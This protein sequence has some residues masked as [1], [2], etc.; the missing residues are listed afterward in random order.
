TESTLQVANTP[1]QKVKPG[2][3]GRPLPGMDVV[4]ID[5]VTNE[6]GDSGEICL[7]IDPRPVGLTPGYYGDPD[8]NANVFRDGF[9]HT[10]DTAE[11][12]EDGYI[13]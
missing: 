3:M 1:G 7:R 4:L 11:R 10:G 5:P 8:K 13:F 12:D 9:Y 6:I 2:S